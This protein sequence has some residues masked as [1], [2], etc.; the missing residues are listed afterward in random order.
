MNRAGRPRT[1]QL[2][3]VNGIFRASRARSIASVGPVPS[4]GTPVCVWSVSARVCVCVC[5]RAA[6]Q[7]LA[8]RS[9]DTPSKNKYTHVRPR[10]ALAC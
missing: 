5:V 9:D 10:L 1:V 4:V 7:S 3:N 2:T 8:V 6:C